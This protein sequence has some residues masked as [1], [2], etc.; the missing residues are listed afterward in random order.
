MGDAQISHQIG[1]Q[2]IAFPFQMMVLTNWFKQPKPTQTMY[3]QAPVFQAS[4]CQ[5]KGMTQARNPRK[6]KVVKTHCGIG[7]GNDE[8]I[9][10]LSWAGF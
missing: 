10:R 6:E 7:P 8:G 4:R 5:G 1:A 2:L 3:M 9:L